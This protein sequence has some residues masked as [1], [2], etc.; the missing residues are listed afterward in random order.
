M[1]VKV[2]TQFMQM[3]ASTSA[4]MV[5]EYQSQAGHVMMAI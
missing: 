1:T 5:S 4:V 3:I 2:E